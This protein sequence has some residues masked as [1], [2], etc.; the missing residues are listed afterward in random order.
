MDLEMA[1]NEMDTQKQLHN[2]I[3]AMADGE[4]A[5]SEFELAFATLDTPAG[6]AAWDLYHEIGHILRSHH[7]DFELSAGF[8][9][10]LSARLAA[11]APLRRAPAARSSGKQVAGTNSESPTPT[12]VTSLP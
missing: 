1:G 6:R 4:L 5:V 3:S 8:A 9:A 12:T 2:Y 7:C 10:R 11:E